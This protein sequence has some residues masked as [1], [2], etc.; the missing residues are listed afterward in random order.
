MNLRPGWELRVVGVVDAYSELTRTDLPERAERLGFRDD[1]RAG[2]LAA[3]QRVLGEPDLLA[4]IDR[5]AAILIEAIGVFDRDGEDAWAGYDPEESTAGDPEQRSPGSDG[6]LPMLVL[7]T[8]VDAIREFHTRRGIPDDVS[9]RSL[10]DLGQQ[11]FVHR[12]TYD[13]FGLHTYGWLRVAWSGA[14]YWLGR[15]QFNL[16]QDEV[17]KGWVVS[18]HIPRTGPLT[19]DSVDAS[20]AAAAA[21]FDRHFPEFPATTLFC[22]SWLLDPELTAG[23]PADSNMAQFQ[24]L[25]RIRDDGRPADADALFFTFNRRGDVDLDTLPQDT[26]LQRLIVKRLRAGEHWRIYSGT[27]AIEPYRGRDDRP[28]ATS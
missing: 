21:F 18:T 15:L 24:G 19:P 7:L 27:V 3:V 9:W 8:T 28:E 16:Q 4:E 20:F 11:V 1:D 6:V 26:T 5:R 23:L 10:S 12:L 25:W 17:E 14:L 22:H 2:L 13:R